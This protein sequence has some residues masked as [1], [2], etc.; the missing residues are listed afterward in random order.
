MIRRAISN[1]LS[2]AINHTRAVDAST[3]ASSTRR[4]G[5]SG[6]QWKI[7]AK[8]SRPSICRAFSI[9]SIASIHRGSGQPME[10]VSAWPLPSRLWL[11]TTEP[12][13]PSPKAD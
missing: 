9:V 5:A 2:N 7:R 8:A 4:A 10:P 6:L 3:S 11:R 13:T 1:L 12:F